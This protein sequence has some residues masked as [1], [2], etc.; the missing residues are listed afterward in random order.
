MEAISKTSKTEK[1][2]KLIINNNNWFRSYYDIC[3]NK[4][5]FLSGA[6]DYANFCNF[7]NWNNFRI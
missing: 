1:I 6:N 5:S 7:I 3:K 4:N 2:I